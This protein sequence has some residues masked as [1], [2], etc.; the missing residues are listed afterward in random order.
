MYKDTSMKAT[1]NRIVIGDVGS[2]KTITSFLIALNYIHGLDKGQSVLLAPTEMLAFQHYSKLIELIANTNDKW[3]KSIQTL[4]ISGKSFQLNGQKITKKSL[5]NLFPLSTPTFFIGTHALLYNENI[6]PD[7]VLVDEQHR[8]GVEQRKLLT[9]RT[10]HQPH[11]ISFSA[12]PIPRT[13][14]LTVYKSLKPHFLDTLKN[15]NKIQTQMYSFERMQEVVE[16]VEKKLQLDQKVYVVCAKVEDSLEESEDELWSVNKATAFFEHHFPDKVLHVYG[17]KVGKK[18]ILQEFRDSNK[19]Q[20]LIATTVIEVGVDVG[21][22]TLM[23]ILNAE[24]FGLSALHQI[25][26][27]VG[28]NS[29]SNNQCFLVT[30]KKYLSSKRLKYIR[31][32]HNGFDIAE[33]DLELRGAGDLLGHTQSGFS[34]EIQSLIGLNPEAYNHIDTI[35]NQLDLKTLSLTLPRLHAYIN[36]QTQAIWSE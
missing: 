29:I 12:T 9:S 32:F 10:E 30:E 21:N 11:F 36:K 25:R 23:I 28:R 34:D 20:I 27:R 4:Y 14:A 1:V 18:D 7:I 3:L 15:R 19:K 2:G 33:K 31:E 8:F 5:D 6:K 16:H 26:G 24:R 17:K 13:L 35:V 22:A